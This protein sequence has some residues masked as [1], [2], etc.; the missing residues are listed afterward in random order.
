[1]FTACIKLGCQQR[2][3]HEERE[4]E[5][6]DH[7][8]RKLQEREAYLMKRKEATRKKVESLCCRVSDEGFWTSEEEVF[9]SITGKC[10]SKKRELLQTQL[11]FRQL[12]FKQPYS[13]KSIF[14]FS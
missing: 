13:D 6:E 1:M 2:E 8:K 3:I 14:F 7:L 5:I 11:H 9:E 10:E 12:V 4:K